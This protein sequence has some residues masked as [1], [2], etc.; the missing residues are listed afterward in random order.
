MRQ[1][2]GDNSSVRSRHAN[3]HASRASLTHFRLTHARH[4]RPLKYYLK[5]FITLSVLNGLS[6][7]E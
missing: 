6:G 4:F 2:N 3:S 1:Q 7:I 5:H